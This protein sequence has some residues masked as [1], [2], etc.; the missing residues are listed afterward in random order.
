MIGCGCRGQLLAGALIDQGHVVRG[1][2]RDPAQLAAIE[3]AGA[4]AVLGDP[5]RVATLIDPL[6]HVSVACLL[7]GSATGSAEQLA[8]LH[9]SRL[10]MLLTKMVDTTVHG[11]VYEARGSVEPELLA[12]GARL[13]R[14]F[15]ARAEA[16]YAMLEADPGAHDAWLQAAIE[17]VEDVLGP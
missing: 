5:D 9:G 7:L 2:T 16:R 3:A 13:V 8:A 11:V 10:E 14:A 6:E 1:T 12:G 17:A 15:G 4:Q